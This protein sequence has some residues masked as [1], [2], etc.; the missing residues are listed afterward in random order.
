M[1]STYLTPKQT[2]DGLQLPLCP[3][4]PRAAHQPLDLGLPSFP[5][6]HLTGFLEDRSSPDN[7]K[8]LCLT[9]S[10][11]FAKK[12]STKNVLPA[13]R[14]LDGGRTELMPLIR[15][16]PRISKYTPPSRPANATGSGKGATYSLTRSSSFKRGPAKATVSG[17]GAMYSLTRSSSFRRGHANATGTGKTAMYSL[18]RSTSFQLQQGPANAA[19]TTMYSITRSSSFQQALYLMSSGKKPTLTRRPSFTRAA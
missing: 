4:P 3:P 6:L 9:T 19:K 11:G 14:S 8:G 5:T 2:K 15:L 16:K 17:K 7:A 10:W 13:K 1:T 12:P 18:T